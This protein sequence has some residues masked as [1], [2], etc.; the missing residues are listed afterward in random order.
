MPNGILLEG[1]VIIDSLTDIILYDYPI[2]I[3]YYKGT[4]KLYSFTRPAWGRAALFRSHQA[5]SRI[6]IFRMTR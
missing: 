6:R 5:V 4:V 2:G 3:N 1:R